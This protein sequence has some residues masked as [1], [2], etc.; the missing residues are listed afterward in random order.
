MEISAVGETNKGIMTEWLR[1]ADWK[2]ERDRW[3]QMSRVQWGD[4]MHAEREVSI[5]LLYAR[6]AWGC[7]GHLAAERRVS[8]GVSW[9]LLRELSN[10]VVTGCNR[11]DSSDIRRVS[12]VGLLLSAGRP[13]AKSTAAFTHSLQWRL[14]ERFSLS[15]EPLH[16]HKLIRVARDDEFFCVK[17]LCHAFGNFQYT[18]A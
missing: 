18:H 2:R 12:Q 5:E 10:D 9:C 11:G 3:K 13:A 8:R 4:W 7:H 1:V 17:Y 6:L 14:C 15:I 16:C